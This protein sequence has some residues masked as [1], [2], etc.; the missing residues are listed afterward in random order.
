M[1]HKL[2]SVAQ[3][4]GLKNLLNNNFGL[5]SFEQVRSELQKINF[6]VKH[7]FRNR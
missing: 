1:M 2:L 3:H 7:L 4:I 5:S 6:D